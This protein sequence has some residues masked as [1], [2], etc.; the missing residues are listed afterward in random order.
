MVAA[1]VA[2]REFEVRR[3]ESIDSTNRYLL[4]QARAGAPEG[5]V[6]VADHQT[7]GRGRLGRVW[8]APPGSSLLCSVLL[9]PDLPPERLHLAVAV[10]AL[11]AR[12][13]LGGLPSLKW[14]NDLLVDDRKLAG[15]LAEADLPAVVVGIGINLTWAPPGA[16]CVGPEADREVV[17]DALLS[18]LA[19]MYGDWALVASRYAAEC[20]TVGRRVRVELAG[21]TFEGVATA[22]TPEGHLVVDGRT[23]TAGD[24]VH[25]RPA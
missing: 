14:P 9:R 17:L 23:V 1:V 20:S 12:D 8:E 6:A 4:D 24:V 16:A 22:V 19:S 3:F 25:L 10:V 11:A 5:V 15:V 2:R 18:S 7:A 13:A 21:E